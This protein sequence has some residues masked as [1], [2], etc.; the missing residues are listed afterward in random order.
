MNARMEIR[1]RRTVIHAFVATAFG[2]AL[3]E[4]AQ[5][6]VNGRIALKLLHLY[7]PKSV[8]MAVQLVPN[9]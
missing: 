9:A 4:C 6:P 2:L 3:S 8:R 5:R 7:P 1:G